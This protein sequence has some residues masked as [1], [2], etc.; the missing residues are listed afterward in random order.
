MCCG[1]GSKQSHELI[2]GASEEKVVAADKHPSRHSGER[3]QRRGEHF[4]SRLQPGHRA[5]W[6]SLRNIKELSDQPRRQTKRVSTGQYT[7]HTRT[8]I[9]THT[10]THTHTHSHSHSPTHSH[11]HT[12]AHTQNTQPHP[13]QP[14]AH[15]E[16]SADVV[17]CCDSAS[18]RGIAARQH[19]G[20]SGTQA[21]GVCSRAAVSHVREDAPHH[22]VCVHNT[23]GR[24]GG[25]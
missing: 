12:H 10:H 20:C 19:P 16:W 22:K 23:R 14:P 6:V 24:H 18:P 17:V 4:C 13:R 7:L 3:H 21:G 11:K 1:H 25:H 5:S 15:V 9:R 8:L 2:S